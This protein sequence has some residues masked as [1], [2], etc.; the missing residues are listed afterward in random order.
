MLNV[1]GLALAVVLQTPAEPVRPAERPGRAEP[2]EYLVDAAARSSVTFL[3]P[4]GPRTLRHFEVI[5]AEG[6]REA[7]S[8]ARLR[9]CWE[10]DDPDAPGPGVDL[11]LGLVF[12]GSQGWVCR[13]PMP[14]RTRAILRIDTE[15]PLSGKIVVKAT[16]GVAGDAGYFRATAW[17]PRGGRIVRE[18]GRGQLIGV[19]AES[20]GVAGR[21]RVSIDGQAQAGGL[22][23]L[24]SEPWKYQRELV[25]SV[26][27]VEPGSG[28][29]AALPARV[30]VFWNADRPGSAASAE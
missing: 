22:D 20:P 6:S 25:L 8:A 12:A 15:R 14:Y 11:P 26:P 24:A 28:S 2:A 30:V 1:L 21:V 10:S 27:E 17:E 5:P 13:S 7:W 16:R 9:L 19:F 4:P 18:T 23:R 3:L 29:G